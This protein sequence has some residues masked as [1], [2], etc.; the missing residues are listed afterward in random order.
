MSPSADSVPD[1][2]EVF[3]ELRE[4]GRPALLLNPRLSGRALTPRDSSVGGPLLWPADAPWPTCSLA[5]LVKLPEPPGTEEV[6]F[7]EPVALQPVLQLFARDLPEGWSLPEGAAVLQVLWCP[8]EH[9]ETPE[10]FGN[11]FAPSIAIRWWHG[12]GLADPLEDPPV[13]HTRDPSYDLSGCPG[14]TL[15]PESTVDHPSV[16]ALPDSLADRIRAWEEE[17]GAVGR[18]IDDTASLSGLKLGGHPSWGVTDPFPMHC[19]ECGTDLE[20]LLQID[21]ISL[22]ETLI[23]LGR[24]Y[25]L[26]V[27]RCPTS[28]AHPHRVNIQ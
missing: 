8:N 14:G 11:L 3:P 5:H 17:T 20:H 9:A 6:V 21:T 4:F 15:T 16:F 2:L 18:Y 24:G 10:S 26:S 12:T 13:P 19:A 25:S 27:Y 23:F 7:D 22:G 1:P 28:L